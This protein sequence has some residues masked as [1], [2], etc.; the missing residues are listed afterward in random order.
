[1]GG[2]EQWSLHID[3]DLVGAL[4]R[5]NAVPNC[6]NTAALSGLLHVSLPQSRHQYEAKDAQGNVR[7][8]GYF[9]CKENEDVQKSKS[10][11]GIVGSTLACSCDL[12]I[13]SVY[14]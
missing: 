2:D 10:G 14:V 6:G 4:P 9:K 1:L 12:V 8:A 13:M 5:L 3:G 11:G 7:A